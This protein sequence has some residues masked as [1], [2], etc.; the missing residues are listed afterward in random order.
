MTHSSSFPSTNPTAAIRNSTISPI[1]GTR[2][3]KLLSRVTFTAAFVSTIAVFRR[4]SIIL[5]HRLSVRISYR[6]YLHRNPFR[7]DPFRAPCRP[8]QG[9]AF[10]VQ[11]YLI[12]AHVWSAQCTV[13]R[14][15]PSTTSRLYSPSEAAKALVAGMSCSLST[16]RSSFPLATSPG[17]V[18]VIV[19]SVTNNKGSPPLPVD[20]IFS[21]R[22]CSSCSRSLH[23]SP[24]SLLLARF[25]CW[26]SRRS[27]LPSSLSGHSPPF[28]PSANG[29]L[30]LSQCPG[31]SSPPLY[32][33]LY[34]CTCPV[35][36]DVFR[37]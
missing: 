17:P 30:P 27:A 19:T 15:H 34:L 6:L 9:S 26:S 25:S 36:T 29:V 12:T 22:S 3:T 20:S 35:I 16:F 5:V 28:S 11:T 14:I 21:T 37:L 8:Q 4:T 31:S 7:I 24:F 2:K 18:R 10:K 32:L 13:Y 1:R 33:Y 23:I